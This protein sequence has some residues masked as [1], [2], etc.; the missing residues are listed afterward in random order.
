MSVSKAQCA[1]ELFE[2]GA[3]CAQAVAGAFADEVGMTQNE[4]FK[5]ASGFGGGVGRLREICGA[6]SGAVLILNLLFG[7]DDI[8]DKSAKDAHY[9]RIQKVLK[10]FEKQNG[11]LICRELLGLDKN[12]EKIPVSEARTAEY[13]KKRPCSKIV[14]MAAEI[15]EKYISAEK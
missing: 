7:N 9:A 8:S 2:Q 10:E 4:V 15:L 11:S 6:A 12:G 14:A 3:N 13:Y 1:R 5:L